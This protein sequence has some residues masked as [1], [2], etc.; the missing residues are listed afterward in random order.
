MVK[1][2]WVLNSGCTSHMTSRRDWFCSFQE[3]G[4]TTILLGDG[5]AVESKGQG[6]VNINTHG[7]SIKVLNNVKYV[8][9]LRRN[10]IS[11]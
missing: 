5:H 8:P 6:S 2:L 11:T 10:L 7:G 4:S 1:D 3:I 9:D